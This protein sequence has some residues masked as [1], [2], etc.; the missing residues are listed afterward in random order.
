MKDKLVH[1]LSSK[2]LTEQ[3]IQVLRHG[4]SFN[5]TDAKTTNMIATVESILSQTGVTDETK[6]L[7]W[8]QVSSFRMTHRARNVFSKVELDALKELKADRDLVIVPADKGRSTVVLDITDYIQKAKRLLE[9][10]QSYVSCESNPIKTLTREINATLLAME[11]SGALSPIDRGVARAQETALVRF[12]GLPKLL[13]GDV[14]LRPIV[15]LKGTPTYGVAKWLFQRLKFLTS[16]SDN[17]VISSIQFLEKI[18]GVSPLPSDV[19]ASFNVT[20]FFTSTPQDLAVETTEL[21]LREEHDE[22]KNCLG[23]VQIIQLLKFCHRTYFT[24][25]GTIYEQ[26]KGTPIC[27]PI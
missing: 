2:V 15:S 27:S 13:K 11:N 21:L 25:D 12:F 8:H 9:Y 14:P 24:I 26:V 18:K 23:H 3:Q 1:N 6:N 5:T 17:T 10:R 4:T 19:M 22:T 16:D 20:P 7:I